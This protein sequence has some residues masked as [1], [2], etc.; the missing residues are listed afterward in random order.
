MVNYGSGRARS[1]ARGRAKI[2]EGGAVHQTSYHARAGTDWGQNNNP[3]VTPTFGQV[4]SMNQWLIR[5]D[6]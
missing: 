2:M 5:N 1:A 6:V 4:A 3:K